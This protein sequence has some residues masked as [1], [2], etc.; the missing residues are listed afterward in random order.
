LTT[1]TFDSATG[2]AHRDEDSRDESGPEDSEMPW[3]CT[4]VGSVASANG[5]SSSGGGNLTVQ[6]REVMIPFEFELQ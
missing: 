6:V 3:T 5:G 4:V 2:C 1:S